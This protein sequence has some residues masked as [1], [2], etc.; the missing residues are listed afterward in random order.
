MPTTP[1]AR[2]RASL[3]GGSPLTGGITSAA[4]GQ[5]VQLSIE[6]TAG[7]ETYKWLIVDYP[8]DFECPEGWLEDP[9]DG[10]YY[11]YDPVPDAFEL[12]HWGK[13]LFGLQI[14]EVWSKGGADKLS[15]FNRTAISIESDSGLRDFSYQE[16]QEFNQRGWPEDQR[17]NLR[18]LTGEVSGL[19]SQAANTILGNGTTSSASP[20]AT[21]PNAFWFADATSGAGNIRL[22]VAPQGYG[23]VAALATAGNVNVDI[24]LSENGSY[25]FF[26]LVRVKLVAGG[27]RTVAAR[28]SGNRVSDT[29]TMEGTQVDV[30]M[31]G[32]A[33]GITLTLSATSGNL[34]VNVANATGSTVNGRVHAGWTL[35]DLITDPA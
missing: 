8:P 16:L 34:R 14:N 20:T 35:E 31:G 10:S 30:D 33:T 18:V 7:V 15:D 17:R 9:R 23:A 24:T 12:T 28:I 6:T 25:D 26:V 19:P 2:L 3:N 1:Y 4:V 22:K 32:D 27:R 21:A 13:Y 29:L 11:S 5:T